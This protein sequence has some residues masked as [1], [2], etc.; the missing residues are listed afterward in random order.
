VVTRNASFAVIAAEIYAVGAL[1]VLVTTACRDSTQHSQRSSADT[2]TAEEGVP[3]TPVDSARATAPNRNVVLGAGPAEVVRRYYEAIR[4]GRYDSAY[5]IWDGGGKASGQTAEQFARGFAKTAQTFVSIG[6]SVSIEGA[7]G[8]QYAT[9]PVTVD[10]ILHG[11]GEQH[12]GGSYT[13]RRA[14]ADGATPEQ[15]RWSIYAAHLEKR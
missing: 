1:M 4:N 11:G 13:L 2:V 15:R 3:A 14:M 8:S 10:A 9:V 6:D 12:F 7:A 5:A